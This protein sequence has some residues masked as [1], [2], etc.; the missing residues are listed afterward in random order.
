MSELAISRRDKLIEISA[1]VFAMCLLL[2]LVLGVSHWVTQRAASVVLSTSVGEIIT[3]EFM[4]SMMDD[5]TRIETTQGTFLVHGTFQA[6]KGHST[7][8]EIRKNDAKMLCDSVSKVCKN[9]V[10]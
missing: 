2:A 4:S 10:D 3:A 5:K 6:V 9:L 7:V 1:F 8:L